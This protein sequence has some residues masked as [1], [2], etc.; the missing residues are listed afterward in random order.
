MGLGRLFRKDTSPSTKRPGSKRPSFETLEERLALTV[1]LNS[2]TAPPI[3]LG[4]HTLVPISAVD[5]FGLPVTYS[6]SSSN[7]SIRANVITTGRTLVLNVTGG[8]SNAFSGTLMI[9]LFEDK[10]PAT[11]AR[12][13][14]LANAGFYNGLRFHRVVQGFVAQGGDPAGNGTGGTGLKFSDEFNGGLTFNSFGLFAM[15]NAGDDD[16]DSQFFITDTATG[17]SF[18]QH[19]NFNHTVFGQLVDGFDTFQRIMSTPVG[20]NDLPISPVTITSARIVNDNRHAILDLSTNLISPGTGQITVKATNARKETSTRTVAITVAADSVSGTPTN[21]RPFLGAVND[22]QT[23]SSTPLTFDVP[24][25]DLENDNL[26]FVVRNADFSEIAP[27]GNVSV[28]IVKLNNT[29]ARITLTPQTGFTGLV[30]LKIG[31]TDKANPV[32]SDFDTQAFNLFVSDNPIAPRAL[33]VLSGAGVAPG[34]VLTTQTPT[35]ELLGPA[36]STVTVRINGQNAGTATQQSISNGEGVYRFTVPANRL[37]VGD[38]IISAFTSENGL[39]SLSSAPLTVTFLPSLQQIYVVPG[40]AGDQVTL[41]FDF[42]AGKTNLKN[43]VGVYVVDDL[44][45][46]VDGVAPGASNYRSTVLA[47]DTRQTVFS[48]QPGG[49]TSTRTLTFA[50]G[51]KLAFYLVQNKSAAQATSATN[52]FFSLKDANQ[53]KIF[54]AEAFTDRGSGRAIYG[55]E[56]ALNGGDHDYNDMVFS[57]RPNTQQGANVGAIAVDIAG[58]A[59]T[60]KTTFAMLPTIVNRFRPMAGEIGIFPVLDL[61]GTVANPT[62]SNPGQVIRPG[63]ANYMQV[64]LS[65]PGTQVLFTK[66]DRAGEATRSINMAGDSLF[67]IYYV[68]R[69]TLNDVLTKN[70]GNSIGPGRPVVYF[71]FAEANPDGGKVHMRSYTN[72]LQ[73]RYAPGFYPRVDDPMRIHLMGVANGGDANFSD[74]ILT[75]SQSIVNP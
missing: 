26:T 14:E 48:R 7:P 62:A 55:F 9:R 51:T 43:E 31:V 58:P 57:I 41:R 21:D 32:Q 1:T 20:A 69:G 44:A 30:N 45:G 34:N 67:G 28:G 15:A 71:S 25:T 64:A 38:N 2:I 65:Q 63:E 74:F 19:L 3:L 66:P 6:V 33:Q 27:N 23:R 60:V 39:D 53:D 42:L 49:S 56:D 29:T 17:T 47:S 72:D 59:T 35:I 68:P 18:P 73:Y 22:R 8:G 52:I 46:R 54:H 12:I 37:T 5:S 40:V 4:K 61:L 10:A 70:A 50:A 75:Y 13:I 36:N 24:A 11:T 16:N